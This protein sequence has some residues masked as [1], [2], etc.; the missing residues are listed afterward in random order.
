M[1]PK[2]QQRQDYRANGRYSRVHPCYHCGKS[3]G[4]DN[5]ES[6]H[7]TDAEWG[8][9]GLQLCKLCNQFLSALPDAEALR[10]LHL[11]DYGR[12]PQQRL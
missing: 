3:T 11:A 1:T 7:C 12:H 6:H 8:D 10:R 5:Y 9:E 2:Q 4:I